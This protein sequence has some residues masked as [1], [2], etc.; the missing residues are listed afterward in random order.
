ME[1][2]QPA[3]DAERGAYALLFG[4]WSRGLAFL[5]LAVSLAMPPH[6][7]GFSLCLM[8]GVFGLPCFGCG[9]T[10]SLACLSHGRLF[11]ALSFHPF[12]VVVYAWIWLAIGASIVGP[13]RR[14]RMARLVGRHELV[15]RIA[16]VGLVVAFVGF[17]LVRL[18]ARMTGGL[19]C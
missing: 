13:D 1:A 6:G 11:E 8:K 7:L 10:R 19:P 2:A 16:L 9:M 14:A 18:V 5:V 12:G 15:V 17:G 4:K 3:Q